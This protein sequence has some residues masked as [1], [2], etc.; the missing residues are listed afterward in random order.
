M[1]MT[2]LNN[3]KKCLK[4]G[5]YFGYVGPINHIVPRN[6]TYGHSDLYSFESCSL[7]ENPRYPFIFKRISEDTV[8][9]SD[10]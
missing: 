1:I 7:D 10:I 4:V 6:N 5:E 3:I 9:G 2:K 8:I